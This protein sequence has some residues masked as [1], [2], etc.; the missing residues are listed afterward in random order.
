MAQQQQQQQQ[1]VDPNI[2]AILGQHQQQ[3]QVLQQAHQ[4]DAQ[5]AANESARKR[6]D[7]WV[8]DQKEKVGDCD[9]SSHKAVRVWLRRIGQAEHRVPQGVNANSYMLALIKKTA[10]DDLLEEIEEHERAQAPAVVG[11]AAMRVHVAASFLGPDEQNVLKEA[12]KNLRQ[13]A[14][15]DLQH[16]NRR[17]SRAADDAYPPPRNAQTE[18]EITDQYMGSLATGKVKDR[19]FSHD[20]QLVNLNAAMQVAMAEYG[21]QRRRQRVQRGQARVEEPMEVDDIDSDDDEEGA[22][23]VVLP[24]VSDTLVAIA[25]TLRTL[26]KE[27][28]D[29]KEKAAS[30]TSSS[31]QA[32]QKAGQRGS[33]KYEKG[34][35]TGNC[36]YCGK[37]RHHQLECRKRLR[38]GAPL[39]SGPPS[40]N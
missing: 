35:K 8:T 28:Q 40:G 20:P 23:A 26:Q 22:T 36:W 9:G 21:R 14:R 39:L 13:T 37:P 18:E 7:K 5:R 30:S 17:F 10:Q 1:A 25:S 24:P 38:D 32:G 12:L 16:Y 6:K 31:S 34:K 2:Q 3:L 27:V 4:Q 19:V 15:E 11:H 33:Q 29:I